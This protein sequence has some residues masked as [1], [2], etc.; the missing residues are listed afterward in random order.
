MKHCLVLILLALPALAQSSAGELRLRVTDPTGLGIRCKVELVSEAN[1][2]RQ[3]YA[4]DGEGKLFAW[5]LPLGVY[6]IEVTHEGFAAFTQLAEVRSSIPSDYTIKLSLAA[7]TTSVTVTDQATLIDPERA[8]T[9]NR[10]G[11]ETIENRVTSLPGRSLQDLVNS[12]PGWLYEGNAVLHP[13]GSEYQTQVVVDGVPLTDNRSPGFAPEIAADDVES[14]SVYTANFP[15]EYGRKMGGVIEVT[16]R[17]DARRGWHG[18]LALSGGSFD[19]GGAYAMTQY[20]TDKN[21]FGVSANGDFTSRYL[22]PPVVQNFTN[23]A[24]TGDFSARYE[25]DFSEKDHLSLLWRHEL[26]RFDIPNE[27]VQQQA[28][29]Q[30]SGAETES[31]GTVSY[32][33]VFSPNVLG[34]VVGMVRDDATSLLSNQLSTPIIA[35]QDRGFREGYV[36][37]SISV[38]HGRHEW[39]GG[40]E[41]DFY[42]IH[43]AFHDVITNPSQFDPGTPTTFTFF[44]RGYDREQSAFVEDSVRL[45]KWSLSAGLRWDHYQLLVEKNAVSP[46]LGIA[47]YF[48]GADLV[49]HASY[50]RIFQTPAFENILLSSSPQV[51]SLNP[52]VLRLPVEPSLG[53][54]YEVGMTKGLFKTLKFDASFYE[55]RVNNFADDDQLL[56]TAVSFPI[57][58]NK[59]SIYGAEAKLE[60]PH[61]K[62]LSGFVS[63]SYM[64]ASAYFPVTGGLFLGDDANAALSQLGGR[65]WV[66]QD[67]RNTL[68]TRFRYEV[69]SWV[70]VAAGT[71]YGSGLPF[72]FDGTAQQALAQY[73]QA[74][75]DRVDFATGRVRPSLSLDLSAGARL[76]Q[77][78]NVQI[79]MQGDVQNLNNRL[80]VI[81]FAGLFSGNAVAPPRS[82]A[83]RLVAG[84]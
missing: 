19:T 5:R 2:F 26:A 61:W 18:E 30:Q 6:R 45:G 23:V 55:R 69:T 37:G 54:Y 67:Q 64:V 38:H 42:N 22:N 65:F 28:G 35:F 62:R 25:R 34:T 47:R 9:V 75:V 56:N 77:K 44:S 10:I 32:Q 78:E 58:F 82:Y 59:A 84:F 4:T 40:F 29:Q 63:Y 20:S 60:L 50:D 51:Q 71:E 1:Q 79:R 74:I 21:T 15:A 12:Q 68:R 33:H 66:S 72:E 73:G 3:E 52:N 13:R 24:N 80:N 70:W 57:A 53:N 14:L 41:G 17:K 27:Q 31:S 7:L 36:K 8:G 76:Y 11:E 81:D 46:R 43:E 49:I 83:L 48:P 16:T 39:K